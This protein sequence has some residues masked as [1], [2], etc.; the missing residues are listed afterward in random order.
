MTD[1]CLFSKFPKFN[2]HGFEI[3]TTVFSFDFWIKGVSV[4]LH[5][6]NQT[7]IITLEFGRKAE[8]RMEES[9]VDNTHQPCV[10]DIFLCE[11]SLVKSSSFQ[12]RTI[13]ASYFRLDI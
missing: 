8:E 2:R 13:T 9:L 3:E 11:F 4:D 1:S 5:R 6:W 7:F 12:P 10:K